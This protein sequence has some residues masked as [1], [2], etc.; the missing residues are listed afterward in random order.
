MLKGVWTALVTPFKSDKS[1]DYD[2]LEKLIEFQI[3][4]DVTGILLLGT[5]GEAPSLNDVEKERIIDFCVGRID[6]RVGVMIGTGTNNF[7]K[8]IKNTQV[9]AKYNPDYSLVITPYYNKST[10][11]GLYQYFKA[12][13]LESSIPI[14]IYNVPSRTGL[15]ISYETTVRVANDFGNIV[16]IKDASGDLVQAAKYLSKVPKSFSLMS[17]DDELTLPFMSLGGKGVISVSANIIPKKIVRLVK[18]WKEGDTQGA[19][20]LHLSLCKL[21]ASMFIETNPIPVKEALFQMGLISKNYRFPMWEMAKSNRQY[22]NTLLKRF[23][24]VE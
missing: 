8:T 17:G 20:K 22:L 3:K 12:V 11:E 10:Q 14:V 18:L 19:K 13:S 2:T 7:D 4:G 23:K 16:A 6:G 5:T 15:N 9:A 24:L 1:V 21:N